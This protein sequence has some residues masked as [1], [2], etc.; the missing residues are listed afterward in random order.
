MIKKSKKKKGIIYH[1]ETTPLNKLPFG[2]F[3]LPNQDDKTTIIG[4]CAHMGNLKDKIKIKCLHF[5]N[6]TILDAYKEAIEAVYGKSRLEQ[7]LKDFPVPNIHSSNLV[8]INNNFGVC[9]VNLIKG[10]ISYT[11]SGGHLAGFI[12]GTNKGGRK[13]FSISKLG[14][15]E[16]W[17]QAVAYRYSLHEPMPNDNPILPV[18]YWDLINPKHKVK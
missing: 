12:S 15:E 2:I 6:Y 16:A 7:I 8:K 17:K 11:G 18:K 9:G 4:F 1:E 3:Y 14:L 13:Y 10:G 5:T